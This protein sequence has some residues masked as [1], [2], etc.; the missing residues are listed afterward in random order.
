MSQHTR[1]PW[2]VKLTHNKKAQVLQKGVSLKKNMR[3]EDAHFI[4][5]GPD[6]LKALRYLE[7][8]FGHRF[9]NEDADIVEAALSKA[10]GGARGGDDANE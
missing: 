2:T 9:T 3:R 1:G 6:L 10:A 8:R 7:Q 5:A 4:A